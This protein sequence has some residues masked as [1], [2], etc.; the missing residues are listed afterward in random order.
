MDKHTP[1]GKIPTPPKFTLSNNPSQYKNESELTLNEEIIQEA[2]KRNKGKKIE[3]FKGKMYKNG[4]NKY[5]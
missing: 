4:N 1:N 2:N 5:F 3:V